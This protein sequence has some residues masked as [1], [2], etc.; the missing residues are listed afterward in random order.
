MMMSSRDDAHSSTK[1]P[2]SIK[3]PSRGASYGNTLA[4]TNFASSRS[5]TNR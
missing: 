2:S 5:T 3:R 4:K 1:R